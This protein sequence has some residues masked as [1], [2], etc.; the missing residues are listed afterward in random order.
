MSEQPDRTVSASVSGA[1]STAPSASPAPSVPSVQDAARTVNAVINA[2]DGTLSC[3]REPIEL[4]VTTLVAGGHLL[5]EDLPG[6]GKTTLARALGTV[7]RGD[8]HRV[9]FTPDMLPSDLTGVSVY[10]QSTHEFD[11]HPGPLFANIVIADEINRA[12]PKTQSAMLEAMAE[13]QVSVDGVTYRLPDPYVVI[14]T[15]NPIE[16]EG[17]FP[18]PEAQIDRFM[19]CTS[20]G[21]PSAYAEIATLTSAYSKRPL[22]RL[23]PVCSTDDIRGVRAAADLVHLSDPVASYIVAITTAT[24]RRDDVRYGASPRASLFLAAMA[25]ARALVAGRGFVLPDD[26]RTLA[27]PVLAHRLV[28]PDTAFGTGDSAGGRAVIADVLEHVPVPHVNGD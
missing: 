1:A 16:L 2:L 11:F 5:L 8:V 4:A 10:N 27:S 28:L 24:R 20:L 25:K 18:L 21:Y 13:G 22:D 26:V 15:Q 3:G 14:A 12:N 7:I 6:V 9:Q 23:R 19:T 17:T